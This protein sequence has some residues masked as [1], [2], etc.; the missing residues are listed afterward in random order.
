[1]SLFLRV[2]Y[3]VLC[4]KVIKDDATRKVMGHMVVF[5]SY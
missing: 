4:Y 3:T 5:G 1:M 2:F